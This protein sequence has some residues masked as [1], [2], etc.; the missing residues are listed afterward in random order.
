MTLGQWIPIYLDTYKRGTI[1]ERSFRSIELTARKIP[2]ELKDT[3]LSDIRPMQL[4]ALYNSFGQTCSKSYMDK[5]RT[6]VSGL[7]STAVDNGYCDRDPT[8]N[9]KIPRIQEHPRESFTPEEVR[10][11][12]YFAMGY[13][14]PRIGVGIIV[15]LTT[16]IR[17]GELLG[18]K[19]SDLSGNVLTINRAVYQEGNRACVQEHVAKTEHSLRSIPLLPEV[20]FLLR[21]LPHK[22]EYLFGTRNGTL[23]NPRNFSRD[24]NTFFVH[25]QDAVPSLRRLPLHCLRHTFATLAMEAGSSLRVVQEMLGHTNINTTARYSHPS[26]TDM[27]AAVQGLNSLISSQKPVFPAVDPVI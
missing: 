13:D 27:R 5:L 19:L 21:T 24:Y 25:L 15:L 23:M 18:L 26:L 8:R 3:E 11:I 6:L 22:G 7:F 16:G 14:R 12:L 20:A 4:Q 2:D 10:D 9:L 17:R 1:K